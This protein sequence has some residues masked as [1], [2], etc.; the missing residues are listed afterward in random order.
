MEI[1]TS[2]N[3][4]A[5]A[6][7][8][9]VAAPSRMARV[10]VNLL[11]VLVA[12]SV[13]FGLAE[14]GL[15][16]FLLPDFAPAADERNLLYRYDST[17]GWFPIPNTRESFTGSRTVTVRHNRQGFRGAD[18][19][20]QDK[21]GVIFLGDSFVWGFDVEE[22]ERFTEKLQ[23]KHPE[24]SVYNLGISG[25]GTDQEF[26][27]LQRCFDQYRPRVVF[28]VYCADN[29]KEDNDWNVRYNG[30]YK[31][32]FIKVGDRLALEG[33][34]VPG[35]ERAFCAAHRTLCRSRVIRLLAR[36]YYSIRQPP[37][38]LHP[39]PT[40]EILGQMREFVEDRGARF[41]VGLQYQ[42]GRVPK[43]LADHRIPFVDLAGAS[44]YPTAGGHWTPE[45]HTV[46]CERIERLLLESRCLDT[47]R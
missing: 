22:T 27:L 20:L 4:E 17:L 38:R 47:I 14:L 15:R 30:Y 8:A 40:L 12:L 33:V 39:D 10:A 28:L 31:P 16:Q 2:K 46:V 19:I 37:A 1:D 18:H 29:D 5:P 43:Y 34:P 32:Y 45:G 11:L 24:W 21:P 13:A 42:K 7:P 41:L 6:P 36:A 35:S 44:R 23:A 25:Y 9:A 26:L 3:N